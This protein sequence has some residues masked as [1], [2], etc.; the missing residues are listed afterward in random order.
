MKK[1]FLILLSV[2]L[3]SSA[4]AQ[5]KSFSLG[6]KIGYNSNTLTNNFDS[7]NSGINNSFQIGAFMRFGKKVYFQPEVNYQLVNGN[8]Y[9]S[10]SAALL[11]Q[12]ITIKSVKIPALIGFKMINNKKI[13]IDNHP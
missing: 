2:A 3:G 10:T 6:P 7:I 4:M 1:I 13:G 8:L 12:D 5:E 11:S 9:K